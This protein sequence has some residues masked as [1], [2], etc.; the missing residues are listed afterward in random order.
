MSNL[1]Q[2]NVVDYNDP[3][4]RKEWTKNRLATLSQ[5]QFWAP[6]AGTDAT[7]VIMHK[8]ESAGNGHS[9]IMQT[10]ADLEG[11]WVEGNETLIGTGEQQKVFEDEIRVHEFRTAKNLGT[12]YDATNIDNL[13]ASTHSYAIEQLGRLWNKTKDQMIF[14]VLQQGVTDR[15]C[16]ADFNLDTF[17]YL[18]YIINSGYGYSDVSDYKVKRPR[19]LPLRPINLAPYGSQNT[20]PNYVLFVD[21]AVAASFLTDSSVQTVLSQAS[22][23][24]TNNTLISGV[25]GKIGNITIVRAPQFFGSTTGAFYDA[26]TGGS[27]PK[28]NLIDFAG[29]RQYIG[30]TTAD[31]KP[32][33]WSGTAQFTTDLAAG[34][35][36]V[37]SRCILVGAGAAQF[38]IGRDPQYTLETFD[39]NHKSESGLSVVVGA[40]TTILKSSN[41][42]DDYVV[43]MTRN[44]YGA[45]AL[46]VLIPDKIV[47]AGAGAAAAV[48]AAAS[49]A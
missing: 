3:L 8:Y 18:A 17:N 29:L 40:K 26:A 48:V 39:H 36:K 25:I 46:D 19:R 14:D 33:S 5:E 44:S 12:W 31:Y 7:S 37:Y 20:E 15:L 16:F 49:K 9:V 32:T 23:R 22:I 41:A 38:A 6:Y 28:A 11:N 2:T 10:N 24:G 34:N 27:R 13:E 42:S 47:Q 30:S 35:K 4:I 45:I 1:G 21:D 43:G